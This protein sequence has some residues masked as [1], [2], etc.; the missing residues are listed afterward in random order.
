MRKGNTIS[1]IFKTDPQSSWFAWILALIVIP[2]IGAFFSFNIQKLPQFII[3][4]NIINSNS[5]IIIKA[6]NRKANRQEHLDIIFDGFIFSQKGLLSDQI[7][8][9]QT[10]SFGLKNHPNVKMY[11][12]L[13]KD[14]IHYMQ[15]GFPGEKRSEKFKI[16]FVNQIPSVDGKIVYKDNTTK[17]LKGN[18][19]SFYSKNRLRIEIF[20]Y[21][22]GP[23]T[24]KIEVPLQNINILDNDQFYCEFEIPLK[25]FPK[26]D[27][28][29]NRFN[30]LFFE[31][32]VIDLA[33]NVYYYRETYGQYVLPGSKQ[34]GAGATDIRFSNTIN[35][36][37]KISENKIKVKQKLTTM[38]ENSDQSI[39]ITVTT[40]L[41]NLKAVRNI[42]WETSTVNSKPLALVFRDKEQIASTNTNSYIDTDELDKNIVTYQVELEDKLGKRRRSHPIKYSL[43]II[44]YYFLIDT[45]NSMW[46][47]CEVLD[48]NEDVVSN[49]FFKSKYYVY[50]K[51]ESLFNQNNKNINIY[52]AYMDTS[53]IEF[54]NITSMIDGKRF[55]NKIKKPKGSLMIGDYIETIRMR[56]LKNN[57][58]SQYIEIHILSDMDES[59]P[60]KT[61]LHL[62]IKKLKNTLTLKGI[63]LIIY[64]H[65]D[66]CTNQNNIEGMF[67]NIRVEYIRLPIKGVPRKWVY[68]D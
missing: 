65:T 6:N 56:I 23:T 59:V 36:D 58:N 37:L 22:D 26:F 57:S 44:T 47:N 45:S 20:Y 1:N 8:G 55:L 62:A 21:H 33:N 11:P 28:S 32:R 64:I 5:V 15:V 42:K 10:W 12:S 3:E 50:K 41:V 14:G 7:E 60:G 51:L 18:A 9:Y 39:D 68:N 43:P 61:P 2:L 53:K 24:E 34:F 17:T 49:F 40:R 4:N 46:A 19:K 13:I 35:E 63:E 67:Y 27:T 38:L 52:S 30:N 16:A 48:D 29:D 66:S 54:F 25:N 31:F